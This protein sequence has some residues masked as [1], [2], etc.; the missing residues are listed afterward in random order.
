MV[1]TRPVNAVNT[2]CGFRAQ[3]LP[4]YRY[5]EAIREKNVKIRQVIVAR[6]AILLGRSTLV[7]KALSFTHELSFSFFLFIT[8]PPCSATMQWMA[9]KCISEVGS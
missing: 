6:L 8:N 5:I 4:V 1:H 9:I 2:E 7:R 3:D